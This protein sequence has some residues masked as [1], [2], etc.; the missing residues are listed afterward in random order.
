MGRIVENPLVVSI[1]SIVRV[2][3]QTWKDWFMSRKKKVGR[4]K[5]RRMVTLENKI[6]R[7]EKQVDD[8]QKTKLDEIDPNTLTHEA[9][10]VI[11]N[12][13]KL[14]ELVILK[15][16]PKK[17]IGKVIERRIVGDYEYKAL[18]ELEQYLLKDYKIEGE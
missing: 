17:E 4:P 9:M 5:S 7:L 10:G 13:D 2:M 12:K 1:K 11:L 3:V 14:Y 8:L 18:F 6:K 15:F 16:C